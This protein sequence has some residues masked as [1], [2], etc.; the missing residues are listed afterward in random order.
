MNCHI[1]CSKCPPFA[2]QS[3]A[4]VF[5]SVVNGFFPVRQTKSTKVY[6]KTRELVLASV[7]AFV[8]T[9]ALLPNLRI[10]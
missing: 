6:F 1:I 4:I 3:L 10:Q 5:H 7:A 2:V 9:P 8:N